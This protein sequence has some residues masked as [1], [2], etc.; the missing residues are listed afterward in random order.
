MKKSLACTVLAGLL[1]GCVMTGAEANNWIRY[2]DGDNRDCATT[3]VSAAVYHD[4]IMIGVGETKE[5]NGNFV[6][7]YASTA[8]HNEGTLDVNSNKKYGYYAIYGDIV[9][10]EN[11][12]TTINLFGDC[13]LAYGG[14]SNGVDDVHHLSYMGA[15]LNGVVI[16]SNDKFHLNLDNAYWG[17]GNTEFDEVV[18]GVS[19]KNYS[20]IRV[21][22]NNIA[23]QGEAL[24]QQKQFIPGHDW[25]DSYMTLKLRNFEN[26]G[27]G[28]IK[29]SVD[30]ANNQ[31]D[32]VEFSGT[33][34]SKVNI[35]LVNKDNNGGNPYPVENGNSVVYAIAPKNSDMK[36]N[37][38]LSALYGSQRMFYK[39]VVE[40]FIEGENKYWQFLGWDQRPRMEDSKNNAKDALDVPN[41]MP[42][43]EE[44]RLE[45]IHRYAVHKDLSE[46]GAWVRGETGKM[47]ADGVDFDVKVISGGYDWSNKTSKG[48]FF[49][50]VGVSHGTS[51]ADM[52]FVGDSKNTSFSVYGSWYGRKNYDYIDFVAKYGKID[53]QYNGI[54]F[55]DVPCSGEYDKKMYSLFAKYGR[56]LPLK[57]GY[58]IEPFGS[59]TYG[60]IG[61]AD[62]YDNGQGAHMHVNSILSKIVSVG[63][64]FG[65]SVKGTEL[66]CKLAYSYDFDGE[67]RGSVPD[68]NYSEK[69][70]MG[71]SSYKFAVGASRNL[72]KQNS[73]HLDLEKDFGG[74]MKRP[75][76]LALT[77]KHTW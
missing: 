5:V 64:M 13:S 7:D 39:P 6:C 22:Q 35:E 67:I 73:L 8:I 9:H 60:H 70:D 30:L 14:S 28:L 4:T 49:M 11:A 16:G 76:N 58:Y 29:L 19:L 43:M 17:I 71:G 54:N 12:V 38:T 15:Q 48:N 53:H 74:K 46:L 77:F 32:K 72:G 65:R 55:D 42:E 52:S 63:A 24:R 25:V 10:G 50:G 45:E 61:D 69:T 47:S 59:V 36:V 34:P 57:N 20:V 1:A 21:N 68:Q 56:R 66:Y 23:V 75:W 2:L 40:D 44:K 18:Y 37:T 62:F 3:R 31:G 41:L 27:T 51:N 33:T 26:D